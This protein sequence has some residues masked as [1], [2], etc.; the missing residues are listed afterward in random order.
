MKTKEIVV[1]WEEKV[2]GNKKFKMKK[3]WSGKVITIGDG[4]NEE[5]IIKKAFDEARSRV[6]EELKK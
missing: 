2:E 1:G 4:D 6:R 5:E 3:A